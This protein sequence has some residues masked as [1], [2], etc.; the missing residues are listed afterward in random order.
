MGPI[1]QVYRMN[2]RNF[3]HTSTTLI[4]TQETLPLRKKILKPF[5]TEAECINPGDDLQSTFHFACKV[6][7]KIVSIATFLAEPHPCLPQA[8]HPYR[9]RGMASDTDLG[10]RQGYGSRVLQEGIE[11]LQTHQ[12]CDAI[13]CN[14]REQAFGFYEKMGFQFFG[15]LFDIKDIGPHKVMYKILNPR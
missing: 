13:W 6:D 9:L 15:E 11:Y 3:A 2:E 4:S 1:P 14:A 12:Q 7:S 10:P 8:L 5:L